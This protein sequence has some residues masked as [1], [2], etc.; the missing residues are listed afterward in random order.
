MTGQQNGSGPAFPAFLPEGVNSYKPGMTIRQWYRGQALIGL[1]MRAFTPA[2]AAVEADR[3]ADAM[4][5]IEDGQER[6]S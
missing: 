5:Q 1:A 2:A 3:Y 4:L 6:A